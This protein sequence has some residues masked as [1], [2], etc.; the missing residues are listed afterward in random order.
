MTISPKRRL[1]I[2]LGLSLVT[3]LAVSISAYL[4]SSSEEKWSAQPSMSL[5]QA[6]GGDKTGFAR[7]DRPRVFTF[8]EDHGQHPAYRT[9]WWYYTGNL[10]TKAGR[11]FGFQLTF[12][13]TALSPE[14]NPK[15]NP[16]EAARASRDSRASAWSTSQVY[17][18]HFALSDVAPQQFH[19][20]QRLSRAAL[21]LA[22]ASATPFRVWLEDWSVEGQTATALPMRLRAGQDDVWL[23]LTLSSDKPV[24][25]QGDNGLSQ[26]GRGEGNAS[27]YYSLT[28]L[29]T[30]GVIRVGG[31]EFQ[32]QGLSWMDREWS[33]SVLHDTLVGWDWFALQ[34]STGQELMF[35]QL[36]Q[37]PSGQGDQDGQGVMDAFSRGT[38]IEPDGTTQTLSSDM[39]QIEVLETWRSPRAGA[40]YPAKWRLRIPSHG[41]DLTITPHMPNQEMHTLIR[42]WEG[43][44]RVQGTQQGQRQH[45]ITGHGYV[46]LT[47]YGEKKNQITASFGRGF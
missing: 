37:A 25:L 35:Y 39:V 45:P 8:P 20:F 16:K 24:V 19:T 41:I 9:E 18:A 47:G 42:Y 1:H 38:L 2:F 31:E 13:R 6:L 27:Y 46:E 44:V 23:D 5:A 40:V 32:V 36:R 33:T 15:S 12:F 17:M 22:G 26:K 14:L 21:A 28:R 4:F 11:H 29:Q 7:A 34:F 43:A 30:S 10:E 3:L